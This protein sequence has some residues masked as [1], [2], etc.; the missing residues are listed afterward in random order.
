MEAR[1]SRIPNYIKAASPIGL[2]RLMLVTA[3][4]LGLQIDFFDIQY[5]N[6]GREK[7]WIAWFNHEIQNDDP[8]FNDQ[9]P[10]KA[11]S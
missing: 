5:V 2:R 7:Y 10:K 9:L 6:D 8:I 3:A 4:K 11:G 1:S